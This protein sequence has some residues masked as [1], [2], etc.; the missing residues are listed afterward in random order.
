MMIRRDSRLARHGEALVARYLKTG[1]WSRQPT[2]ARFRAVVEEHGKRDAVIGRDGSMTYD[3][4]DER[5]DQIAAWLIGNGLPVGGPVVVQASNSAETVL[6]FYA[7]LKSGAVPVAAL[8]AHRSHEIGHISEILQPVAHLVDTGVS[9]G[10]LTGIALANAAAHPSIQHLLAIGAASEDFPRLTDVGYDIPPATARTRVDAVQESIHY[11]DVVVF[12]LSGGT[13]GTP[14]VI[15]RLH[16]EYWNNAL[17]N[18]RALRRDWR[19]RTAHVMPILHNAGVVN[20]LFGAHS[21]GG[22]VVPLPFGNHDDTIAALVHAGV[23]DMMVISPMEPWFDHP[24]WNEVAATLQFLIYSGSKPPSALVERIATQN[25]WM[26]QTWGMAEGPYTTTRFAAPPDLRAASVGTPTFDSDDETLV[27][28]PTTFG[29]LPNG[30]T[31]LLAYRGPSTIAGYFD[32][33]DHNV[34]AFDDGFLL[35]GD[36]ARVIDHAGLP[37]LALEGRIKD[38]I[39]RGAEKISTEEVEKLLRQHPEIVDAAVVAMPDARLGERACAYV[40]LAGGVA[41]IRLADVRDHFAA[42]GVAK[43]K[44]PERLEIVDALPRTPTLKTDKVKLRQ[45]IA[46]RLVAEEG[47]ERAQV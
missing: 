35:T 26:G 12:Q 9:D 4:L 40:T 7:L 25:I 22:C 2:I 42:L 23:S 33:A 41:T 29:P 39:S 10:V 6:A 45:R 11:E 30:Q 18:S 47:R 44:W 36:M 15:P 38:V 16:A 32:A 3:D 14:K 46:A 28:D 1:S 31:G 5:S 20:A 13:T 24:R 27:V 43:F 34:T 37:Y 8:P 19:S 21:V 17:F